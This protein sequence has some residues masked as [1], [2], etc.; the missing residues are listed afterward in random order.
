MTLTLV[1]HVGN[2][3][4]WGLLITFVVRLI[5]RHSRRSTNGCNQEKGSHGQ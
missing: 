4:L 1:L 3:V 5:V 2:L